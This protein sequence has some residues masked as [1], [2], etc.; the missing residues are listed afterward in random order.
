MFEKT[1]YKDVLAI[2]V[3]ILIF[4]IITLLIFVEIP[5]KNKEVMYP[6]AGG[7]PTLLMLILGYYFASSSGSAKKDET[8]SNLTNTNAK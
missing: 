7:L 3:T 2:V 5:E 6:I 8:I 4:T 1:R